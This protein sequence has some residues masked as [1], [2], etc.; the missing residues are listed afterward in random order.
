ML[1]CA[2]S[3]RLYNPFEGCRI[4]RQVLGLSVRFVGGCAGRCAISMDFSPSVVLFGS[5]SVKVTSFFTSTPAIESMYETVVGVMVCVFG[6]CHSGGDL[7]MF[8]VFGF[9]VEELSKL[10]SKELSVEG[11]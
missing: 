6:V 4:F 1:R 2:D 7:V 3:Q 8:P 10:W 9:L 5:A 11:G